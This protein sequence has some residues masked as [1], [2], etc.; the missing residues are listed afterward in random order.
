MSRSTLT[1]TLCNVQ[2]VQWSESQKQRAMEIFER[3]GA[4]EASK[5]TG[6]PIATIS[7]WAR[8]SGQSAVTPERAARVASKSL[9]LAERRQQLGETFLA[10]A[11]ML[12]NCVRSADDAI[13]RKR[14]IEAARVAAEAAQLL[15]GEATSR[16]ETVNAEAQAAAADVVRQLRAV[17]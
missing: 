14:G 8:R 15:T 7:S 2:R 1:A 10:K 9:T 5:Q 12:I 3:S 6:V 17:A 4:A 13:D 16:V 11:E